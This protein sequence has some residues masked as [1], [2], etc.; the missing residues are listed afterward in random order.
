MKWKRT[1]D[2]WVDEE[3][4]AVSLKPFSSDLNATWEVVD[5][6][7]DYGFRLQL[8]GSRIWQA[9]FYKSASH[10]LETQ[11]FNVTKST[12]AEAICVAALSISGRV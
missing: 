11:A 2:Q 7:C 5:K 12:P 9:R 10:T 8:S 6:V 4:N 1:G 3:G